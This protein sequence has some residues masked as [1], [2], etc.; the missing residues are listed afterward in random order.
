M[1]FKFRFCL[2]VLLK[3]QDEKRDSRTF[4][5]LNHFRRVPRKTALADRRLADDRLRDNA[6]GGSQSGP[7]DTLFGALPSNESRT[8]CHFTNH[9][10]SRTHNGSLRTFVEH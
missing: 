6:I 5:R 7:L 10:R 8:N 2:L 1:S 3:S 9:V 4:P